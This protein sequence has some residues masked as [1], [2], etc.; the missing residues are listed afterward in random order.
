MTAL[1]TAQATD[2]NFPLR[3]R[4]A[5][6][7]EQPDLPVEGAETTPD[8]PTEFFVALSPLAAA[9]GVFTPPNLVGPGS[10]QALL[11]PQASRSYGVTGVGIKIG[12]LSDSFNSRGGLGGD[13]ANGS[14]GAAVKILK[15]GMASGSDEGRAMAELIHKIAPG[16]AIDFYSGFYGAADMAAGVAALVK[17]GCNIIVDDI[18]YLNEPF[19][20]TGHGLQNAVSAAIKSGVSYFT[21]ASNAGRNF[22]E[23]DFTG[24]KASLPGIAGN[25]LVENFGTA[26]APVTRQSL[27]I[28]RGTTSTIDLQWDQP[29]V[30]IGG[31]KGAANSLGM[32]LYNSNNQIV[33]YATLNGVN[34]NPNQILQFTNTTASTSFSLGIFSNCGTTTPGLFKYIVYGNGTTINDSKAGKGSGTLIGHEQVGAANV[35]GAVAYNTTSTFGGKNVVEAFSSVGPSSLLFDAAGNRLATPGSSGG[36]DFVAPDGSATNVF[37]P[38]FGTSAAA[39]NAAAGAALMLQANPLL[40]PAQVSA[41]LAAS[42]LA[43]I[44]PVGSTGAGLIQATGAVKF[45]LATLAKPAVTATASLVISAAASGGAAIRSALDGTPTL[46][47]ADALGSLAADPTAPGDFYAS[48]DPAIAAA[49]PMPDLSIGAGVSA[50]A[51]LNNA[52]WDLPYLTNAPTVF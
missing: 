29:F 12:I 49:L 5:S 32:A 52:N 38:F 27:T 36:V 30:G 51:M 28:G 8:A 34:R 20:Q 40:T 22:Y 7:G 6:A 24:V 2:K 45:A 33:S 44:G 35:V 46:R 37:N 47:M 13:I 16:A 19:F 4:F 26:A 39:P 9:A 1:N 21:S 10:A 23:A 11:A 43:A 31:S 25:Y 15:E 14:L 41:G 17:D 48:I 42:A 18:T 3:R 50:L